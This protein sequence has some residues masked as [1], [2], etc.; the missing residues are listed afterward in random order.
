MHW[1]STSLRRLLAATLAVTGL[2]VPTARADRIRLDLAAPGDGKVV[3]ELGT[4]LDWLRLQATWEIPGAGVFPELSPY[5]NQEADWRYATTAEVCQRLQDLS[6]SPSPCPGDDAEGLA[7]AD[8]DAA[9]AAFEATFLILGPPTVFG[10]LGVFPNAPDEWAVVELIHADDGA[11][12][13][14][15]VRVEQDATPSVPAWGHVI[16]R[17]SAWPELPP[18]S[19]QPSGL[20]P[21]SDS[22]LGS[23]PYRIEDG[24]GGVL[25]QGVTF[26]VWAPNARHV[27][28]LDVTAM[29]EG[30]FFA[31]PP[32]SGWTAFLGCEDP[33]ELS[34]C[35]SGD[36]PCA[37]GIWSGDVPDAWTGDRYRYLTSSG[38][39]GT[40]VTRRDPRALLAE[41]E[42]H[43]TQASVVVDPFES[44][45]PQPHVWT[46]D[47]YIRPRQKELVLLHGNLHFL[48]PARTFA[49]AAGELEQIRELGVN[50][51]QLEPLMEH[52]TLDTPL[53]NTLDPIWYNPY[54][55]ADPMAIERSFGGPAG[56]KAF[57]DAAHARGLSVHHEVKMNLWFDPGI[58]NLYDFDG[59]SSPDHPNGIYIWDEPNA[60][61]GDWIHTRPNYG[62]DEVRDYLS[63]TIRQWLDD[64]HVDGFRFDQAGFAFYE[65]VTSD[66]LPDG[67]IARDWHSAMHAEMH[68][69]HPRSVSVAENI[70]LDDLGPSGVGFDA[71]WWWGIINNTFTFPLSATTVSAR[72]EGPEYRAF[73][74]ATFFR[75]IYPAEPLIVEIAR[76]ACGEPLPVPFVACAAARRRLALVTAL[77][78]TAPGLPIIDVST[79]F[80]RDVRTRP[81]ELPAGG[82]WSD[83]EPGMWQL[84]QDLIHLRR[85]VR[86]VPASGSLGAGEDVPG[87]TGGLIGS[88]FSAAHPGSTNKV[89]AWHR[90]HAGGP[91]DDVFVAANLSAAARTQTFVF[92]AAGTWKVRLR[93]DEARFGYIAPASE[94]PF[95]AAVTVTDPARSAVLT[96]QPFTA[97]IFSQ[98]CPDGDADGICDAKDNCSDV[99]TRFVFDADGDGWG[100]RC[101]ADFNNDGVVGGPDYIFLA[102]RWGSTDRLADLDGDGVVGIGDFA[103]LSGSF[104]GS[105]GPSGLACAGSGELCTG[106]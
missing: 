67:Q 17:P 30:V 57:V 46:D 79:L 36:C 102:Q 98:D 86:D 53:P 41:G 50:A 35:P 24:N 51:L 1:P 43:P 83:L 89:L 90:W 97:V 91:G 28:V 4:G 71:L 99:A 82:D 73:Q 27:A 76:S 3:R 14:P 12:A 42:F 60:S 15:R 63:D 49:E 94:V 39:S 11:G 32:E 69:R 6:A 85:D 75:E 2:A 70:A 48:S 87:T 19:R 61:Q 74:Q 7:L 29:G 66:L 16:V 84:F 72:F 23:F 100:N 58:H 22:Y 93:T 56:Y 26:R 38:P 9:I 80:L 44:L 65:N 40:P 37:S 21:G 25:E 92:P 55:V 105:P 78:L 104:G 81:P 52:P 13:Y 45:N 103:I 95:P 10:G 33:G 62:S 54:A 47:Y 20:Q 106:P 59:W 18:S 64:F 101:D 77:H 88:G 8:V 34:W 5:L 96:L 31:G 68:E